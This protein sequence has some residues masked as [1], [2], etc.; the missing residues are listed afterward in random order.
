MADVSRRVV[1]AGCGVLWYA[2]WQLVICTGRTG[3][4]TRDARHRLPFK[5]NVDIEN[6]WYQSSDIMSYHVYRW[7]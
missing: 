7:G 4:G 5:L 3:S 6:L 1:E 2:F